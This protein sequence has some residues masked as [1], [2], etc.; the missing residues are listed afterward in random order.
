MLEVQP[1]LYERIKAAQCDYNVLIQLSIYF[2]KGKALGF[3][4]QDDGSL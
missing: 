4:I 1:D 3:V 2:H